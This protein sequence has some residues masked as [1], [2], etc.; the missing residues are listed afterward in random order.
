MAASALPARGVY[1]Y[2]PVY[3]AFDNSLYA[4]YQ[5]T[6]GN[7]WIAKC[8][9]SVRS[10]QSF[11]L[12][13]VSVDLHNVPS[14]LRLSS[15]KLLASYGYHNGPLYSRTSSATDNITA[16]ASQVTVDSSN[17]GSFAYVWQT[18]DTAATI[19]RWSQYLVT[20]Y[21]Q[22]SL[23]YYTS[24]NDGASWNA[25]VTLWI[26]DYNKGMTI[27]VMIPNGPN[28]I[29]F[30]M[31]TGN[32]QLGNRISLYHF[33]MT[34]ASNGTPS[35]F[36]STG[37]SLGSPPFSSATTNLTQVYDGT[38]TSCEPQDLQI[39]GGQPV[40]VFT[41]WPNAAG[42]TLT[43]TSARQSQYYQATFNGTTWST[44]LVAEGG[45]AW[46]S[47]ARQ[48]WMDSGDTVWDPGICQD[49]NNVNIVYM[50]KT[51]NGVAGSHI[52]DSRIEQWT[53]AGG[54]SKTADISG[55]TSSINMNVYSVYGAPSTSIVWEDLATWTNY[56]TYT[57]PILRIYPD[58]VLETQKP[59][60][61]IW[62]CTAPV[63]TQ[64][65]WMF[66]EGSG[67]NTKELVSGTMCSF[68][69]TPIWS[70]N[71][72]G[73]TLTGFSTTA[74]VNCDA[75]AA[76]A[77]STAGYPRYIWLFA[78][79]T[80]ATSQ[81]YAF[82]FAGGQ[83]PD[84]YAIYINNGHFAG[85]LIPHSGSSASIASGSFQNDGNPHV[86]CY[87][88]ADSSHHYLYVDGILA[89]T[90]TTTV[91]AYAFTECTLARSGS[92][93][94]R[95]YRLR[96]RLSRLVGALAHPIRRLFLRTCPLANSAALHRSP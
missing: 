89:G 77:N 80:L 67:T 37:T 59:T 42:A 23:V 31:D 10:W 35:Y 90:S 57:N 48:D 60:N 34:V 88:S 83:T 65:Y 96:A 1:L 58:V 29:D 22:Y 63:G 6:A 28:R 32:A 33:Y 62:P 54:W 16:W 19:W 40:A 85:Q 69:G 95:M 92:L 25:P 9:L 73:P 24:T 75:F 72:Y 38:T 4:G 12:G 41:I 44:A 18:A 55:A 68:I 20:A 30:L 46:N 21:T 26:A 70:S 53:N 27:P 82:A 43:A 84:E 52:T 76:A 39:V 17:A 36:N 93:R 14:V 86:V 15:G 45:T 66:A 49:P 50:A 91:G 87:Y 64:A 11:N 74:A 79:T 7:C 51:Y 56:T 13:K 81:Q 71:S 5:D 3:S 8:L 2:Q 94:R 61:P 47:G 78:V